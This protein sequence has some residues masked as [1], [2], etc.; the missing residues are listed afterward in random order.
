[1]VLESLTEE[2]LS[3]LRELRVDGLEGIQFAG[4]FPL[5]H[6]WCSKLQTLELG[7]R[8]ASFG[9]WQVGQLHSLPSLETLRILAFSVEWELDTFELPA[10]KV[11]HIMELRNLTLRLLQSLEIF[12]PLSPPNL[13]RI[14][15]RVHS[16][17]RSLV[18]TCT[19]YDPSLA[20]E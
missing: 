18:I 17:L 4:F 20:K 7:C 2:W 12:A 6:K 10:L 16:T 11:I 1:M 14:L 5:L 8:R 15:G 3:G 9:G 13:L 19:A